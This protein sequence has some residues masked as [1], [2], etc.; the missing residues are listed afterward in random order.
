MDPT[1]PKAQPPEKIWVDAVDCLNDRAS[2]VYHMG[3]P[4]IASVEYVRADLP[5]AAADDEARRRAREIIGNVNNYA[6]EHTG[7]LSIAAFGPLAERI[8]AALS[9]PR[10]ETGLTVEAALSEIQEMVPGVPRERISIRRHESWF[11]KGKNG[12]VWGIHVADLMRQGATLDEAM[13][14]IRAWS[15]SRAERES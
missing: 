7:E 6:E 12:L 5:R 15:K 9:T 14:E 4:S 10:P 8:A 3:R 2:G 13:K 11:A 1:E